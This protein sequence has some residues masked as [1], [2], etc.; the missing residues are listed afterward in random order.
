MKQND[1]INF[2]FILKNSRDHLLGGKILRIE[3]GK[4]IISIVGG[5]TGFYGDFEND[6][7]VAILHQETRSMITSMFFD[8]NGD[9]V[10]GF[11]PKDDVIDFLQKFL[12]EGFR[13]T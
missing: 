8:T 13:V 2:D 9:D 7:E 1:E 4:L 12:K 10:A 11:V 3:T 5:R 6:F